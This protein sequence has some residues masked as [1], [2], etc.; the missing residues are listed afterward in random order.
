MS[1]FQDRLATAAQLETPFLAAFNEA[2]PTHRIVK[3]GIESTELRLIHDHIRSARDGTSSFI[4]YLPDS[5]LVR[6][7][8]NTGPARI[9]TA[10][11]EFK[12]QDTLIYSDNFF[13]D[14][15]RSH[16]GR[17]QDAPPLLH[18]QDIFDME[19]ASLDL[20]QQLATIDVAVVVVC[21]QTQRTLDPNLFRAQYA[22]SIVTC[23]VHTPRDRS[24]G[25]G[26]PASNVHFDSLVP[27]QE[28]FEK[29]FGIATSVLDSVIQA[30]TQR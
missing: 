13:G 18:K 1:S 8:P 2:C 6:T 22:E 23:H 3:F 9:P 24:R 30:V 11:L 15:R 5:A 4:R 28:F 26:T 7:N 14:I 12:V 17:N 16:R 21:W 25:S 19:K 20:Y 29:E 10:L 27:L